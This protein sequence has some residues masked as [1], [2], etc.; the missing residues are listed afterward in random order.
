MAYRRWDLEEQ[1]KLDELLAA[2][3]DY[4]AVAARLGR[5]TRAVERKAYKSEATYTASF[6]SLHAVAKLVGRPDPTVRRWLAAHWLAPAR[7]KRRMTAGGRWL[8]RWEDVIAFLAD[9][10]YSRE[11][12]PDA[13][14]DSGL[15]EWAREA[16]RGWENAG[17]VPLTTDEAAARLGYSVRQVRFW[18]RS[19]QLPYC[20][21]GSQDHDRWLVFRK[22]VDAFVPP[23][24]RRVASVHRTK[25]WDVDP[26]EFER[27]YL[28]GVTQ[29]EL[30]RHYK[31]T[32]R[33]VWTMARR[34]GLPRRPSGRASG[35]SS[36]T[37]PRTPGRR[38]TP[39]S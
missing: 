21:R 13:L 1:A 2:G 35:S 39:R 24:E 37:S 25:R 17:L 33:M 10:R 23:G 14:A 26:A 36:S 3:H 31:V 18:L 38:D 16:R 32:V 6:L 9:P 20:A 7:R 22:D 30:A 19:G 29:A 8:L 12:N 28:T 27:R 15:R 34:L 5:S 4:A 11:W